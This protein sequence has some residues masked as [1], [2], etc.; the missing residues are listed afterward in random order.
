MKKY[1]RMGAHWAGVILAALAAFKLVAAKIGAKS[2]KLADYGAKVPAI[3]TSS[4]GLNI[5]IG[6][7]LVILSHW[8]KGR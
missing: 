6:V 3:P 5:G 4:D 1:L 7:G 2:P 8:L